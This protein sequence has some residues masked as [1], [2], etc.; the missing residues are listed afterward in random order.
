MALPRNTNREESPKVKISRES[1]REALVIFKYLQPYRAQ[2]IGGLIFIALSA[3]NTMTFPLMLQKLIDSIPHVVG[4]ANVNVG[5]THAYPS[6]NTIKLPFNLTPG[7]V[8]LIMIGLLCLQMVIS[9]SRIY[10]FTIVGENAVAD[11]RKD[12]YKHIIMMPMD[13]FAQR[14]VGELSSRITADVSQ[15]QTTVT[16]VFAEI[17][18][19]VLTLVIGIILLLFIGHKMTLL[20][21]S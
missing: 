20:M 13:F 6:V 9:Y 15:I 14:R 19:G 16:S 17:I 2:F 12:I 7:T 1:M 5:I 3:A 4:V 11:M 10:L 8:A 21:L 18:R